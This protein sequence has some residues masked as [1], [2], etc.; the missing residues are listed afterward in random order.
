ME[1][2]PE[3]VRR[4]AR[5]ELEELDESEEMEARLEEVRDGAREVEVPEDTQEL[6]AAD[7]D[8]AVGLEH[9]EDEGEAA[10]EAGQ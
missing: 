10:S 3:E 7:D 1:A 6:P 4:Q 8:I 5:R 2:D 9:S